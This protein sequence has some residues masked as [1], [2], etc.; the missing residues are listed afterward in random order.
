MVA[1][2]MGDRKLLVA[3]QRGARQ[4]ERYLQLTLVAFKPFERWSLA[5]AP[6]CIG[7]RRRFELSLAERLPPAIV[8]GRPLTVAMVDVGGQV[9]VCERP[10]RK[11]TGS[12]TWN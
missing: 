2:V 6:M 5:D 11:R 1:D 7:N 10:L 4:S 12:V 3:F 9:Q 8:A